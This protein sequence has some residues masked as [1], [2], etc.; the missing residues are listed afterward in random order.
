MNTF[1]SPN[2]QSEKIK[3]DF[4]HMV[5]FWLKI[6]DDRKD[7]QSFE[8]VLQEFI[9]TNSQVV[10]FH[11]VQPAATNRPVVDF[12]NTYSLVVS[13]SDLKPTML[14]KLIPPIY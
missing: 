6:P 9:S 4:L 7:R 10:L 14:I 13:F 11:I 5:F 8:N 3:G 2:I 1:M 12:S